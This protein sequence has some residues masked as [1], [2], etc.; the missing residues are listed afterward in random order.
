MRVV[1]KQEGQSKYKSIK[2]KEWVIPKPSPEVIEWYEKKKTNFTSALNKEIQE[3]LLDFDLIKR[4]KRKKIR[5]NAEE[6]DYS[7]KFKT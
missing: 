2:L 6:E 4:A 1:F 7:N 3:E 5:E